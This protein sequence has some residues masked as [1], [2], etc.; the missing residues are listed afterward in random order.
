MKTVTGSYAVNC[1]FLDFGYYSYDVIITVCYS[2]HLIRI[3]CPVYACVCD[4][5]FILFFINKYKWFGALSLGTAHASFE[6][7]VTTGTYILYL[8]YRSLITGIITGDKN[9]ASLLISLI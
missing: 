5:N 1:S 8:V 7:N 3:I 4:L 2:L 6:K 9:L